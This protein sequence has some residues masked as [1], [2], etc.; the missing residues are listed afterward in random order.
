MGIGRGN[1]AGDQ[2]GEHG[3][4]FLSHLS[5]TANPRGSYLSASNHEFEEVFETQQNHDKNQPQ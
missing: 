5:V 4:P 1:N 2:F 3:T